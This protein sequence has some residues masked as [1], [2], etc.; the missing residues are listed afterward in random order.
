M[1]IFRKLFRISNKDTPAHNDTTSD[2]RERIVAWEKE[3]N[4]GHI[5]ALAKLYSRLPSNDENTSAGAARII[6]AYMSKRTYAQTIRLSDIFRDYT[7]MEWYADWTEIRP[8]EFRKHMTEE[9][10]FWILRLGTFHPNGYYRQRCLR[11]LKKDPGCMGFVILRYND[12]AKEV[13]KEAANTY[14]ALR[15]QW[16]EDVIGLLP[17]YEKAYQGKRRDPEDFCSV[18]EDFFEKVYSSAIR[19]GQLRPDTNDVYLRMCF[20]R[21]L[22]RTDRLKK[23]ELKS[24]LRKENNGQC[25]RILVTEYFK[26]TDVTMEDIDE[27]LSYRNTFVQRKALERK[28]EILRGYW[29]GLENMLLS[30]SESIRGTVCFILRNNTDFDIRAYYMDHLKDAES[31]QKA[32]CIWGIGENGLASDWDELVQYLEEDNKNIIKSVLHAIGNLDA[33]GSEEVYWKYLQD[34]R[35]DVMCQAFRE[36]ITH[37]IRYGA[38]RVY[39]LF[40]KTESVLLKRKLVRILLGE[41]CWDRMPYLLMLYS[42]PDDEIRNPVRR[43]IWSKAAVYADV[44]RQ[45]ADLIEKTMN[46]EQYHIPESLKKSITFDLRHITI[47]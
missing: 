37:D 7:S 46:D 5:N 23:D 18:E 32:I 2:D 35:I 20:Y 22:V 3:L 28:Y 29:D 26:N 4:E 34:E 12:W 17:Y 47:K 16:P 6:S 43:T 40:C 27:L 42:Y 21:L 38:E 11:E 39:D 36:I 31:S 13:R 45:Q 25:L 14:M 19:Y 10:Y 8:E 15:G 24:I 9:E 33:T 41:R 44:S 30:P 1:N